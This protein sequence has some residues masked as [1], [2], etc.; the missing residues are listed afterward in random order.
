MLSV[1]SLGAHAAFV[2]SWISRRVARREP[3]SFAVSG[4]TFDDSPSPT[5]LPVDHSVGALGA[6]RAGAGPAPPDSGHARFYTPPVDQVRHLNDDELRA[7]WTQ[8]LTAL[9]A[10]ADEEKRITSPV[11]AL[12]AL[13]QV[14]PDERRRLTRARM[15]AAI[16]LPPSVRDLVFATRAAAAKR[17][18][19]LDVDDNSVVEGLIPTIPEA[20][21]F[22]PP[23]S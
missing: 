22:R 9:A 5:L 14:E 4:E 23:S 7:W 12:R 20:A 3:C 11:S 15:R 17:E 13:Q 10:E 19:A 8:L 21:G 2:V 16:A 1:A 6:T 18:P